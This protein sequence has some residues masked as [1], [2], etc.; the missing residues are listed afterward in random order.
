MV[1]LLSSDK[2]MTPI[3]LGPLDQANLYSQTE[4]YRLWLFYDTLSS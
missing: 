1:L 3:L 2:G 4:T